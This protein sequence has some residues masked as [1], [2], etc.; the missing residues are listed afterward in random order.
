MIFFQS[1]L[2]LTFI[3][4]TSSWSVLYRSWM[5]LAIALWISNHIPITPVSWCLFIINCSWGNATIHKND[6]FFR[7][8][9]LHLCNWE[10]SK[11]SLVALCFSWTRTQLR[12]K[13]SSVWAWSSIFS[14]QC[15]GCYKTYLV[16]TGFQHFSFLSRTPA[17]STHQQTSVLLH[18]LALRSPLDS[19]SGSSGSS[20]SARDVSIGS[21]CEDEGCWR[22][23]I[24]A[25]SREH[26]GITD[27]GERN[28]KVSWSSGQHSLATKA[29]TWAV[30]SH[31]DQLTRTHRAVQS[32][33]LSFIISDRTF[34]WRCITSGPAQWTTG[35]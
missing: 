10:D 23:Y 6:N 7:D 21:F 14:C 25:F 1:F 4:L 34:T 35:A 12:R 24:S 17:L 30:H 33:S 3:L 9:Q 32:V 27:T 16:S 2:T 15:C 31:I 11:G 19:H 28:I 8:Q 13:H 22:R 18:C 26:F 29:R 20:I 5:V